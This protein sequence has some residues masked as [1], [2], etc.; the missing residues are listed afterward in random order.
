MLGGITIESSTALTRLLMA[1]L[2][3]FE[4]LSLLFE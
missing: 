1:A 2:C 4:F 3:H